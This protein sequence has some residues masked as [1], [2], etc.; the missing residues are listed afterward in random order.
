MIP[1]F[2][3]WLL[4]VVYANFSKGAHTLATLLETVKAFRERY[5]EREAEFSM[6]AMKRKHERRERA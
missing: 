5:I 6:Y 4:I 3:W 1:C 2:M